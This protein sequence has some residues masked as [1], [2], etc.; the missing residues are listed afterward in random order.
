MSQLMQDFRNF[1]NT[2]I[3]AYRFNQQQDQ[4]LFCRTLNAAKKIVYDVK[5]NSCGNEIAPFLRAA[6]RCLD[7]LQKCTRLGLVNLEKRV[8]EFRL[9]EA[10]E[11]ELRERD[12]RQEARGQ[13]EARTAA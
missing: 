2:A 1:Q 10:L 6:A 9:E 13:T 12:S 4:I 3:R 8:Q 7:I 5:R 11:R